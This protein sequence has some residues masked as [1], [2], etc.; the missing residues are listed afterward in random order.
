MDKETNLNEGLCY[1]SRVH[2]G[3]FEFISIVF[4]DDCFIEDSIV[5]ESV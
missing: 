3:V 1:I 2:F 4:F 5:L